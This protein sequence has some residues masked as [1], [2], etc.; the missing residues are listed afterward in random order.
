MVYSNSFMLRSGTVVAEIAPIIEN[1][2]EGSSGE[3]VVIGARDVQSITGKD[4]SLIRVLTAVGVNQVILKTPDPRDIQRK[5]VSTIS[6]VESTEDGSL[7]LSVNLS[8][9]GPEPKK[10]FLNPPRVVDQIAQAFADDSTPG[11]AIKVVDEE[12]LSSFAESLDAPERKW[13]V[14][15]ATP[16]KSGGY[17]VD[18]EKLRSRLVGWATLQVVPED[19]NFALLKDT[20]GPQHYCF[21]GAIKVIMPVDSVVQGG[22]VMPGREGQVNPGF[23]EQQVLGKVAKFSNPFHQRLQVIVG[24]ESTARGLTEK[25]PGIWRYP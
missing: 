22:L 1:W 6:L 4:G 25:N 12:V 8:F 15:L 21:N 11:I 23:N 24:P 20:L 19:A 7:N 14:V 16:M 17:A 5:W 10:L 18:L 13:P 3:A 9:K 2:I